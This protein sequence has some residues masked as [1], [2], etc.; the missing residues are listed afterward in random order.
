VSAVNKMVQPEP[1]SEEEMTA[2]TTGEVVLRMATSLVAG[3]GGPLAEGLLW[4]P[5]RL[6]Q[7]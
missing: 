4:I 7:G 2:V 3:F 1:P 6:E 5:V